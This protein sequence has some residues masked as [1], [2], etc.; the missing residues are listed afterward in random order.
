[1]I[2]YVF[3]RKHNVI[4]VSIWSAGA[5]ILTTRYSVRLFLGDCARMFLACVHQMRR[6]ARLSVRAK[7]KGSPADQW[8]QR[9]PLLDGMV[10]S[11]LCPGPETRKY[12]PRTAAVGMLAT[13]I[14][15][16]KTETFKNTQLWVPGCARRRPSGYD[17]H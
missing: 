10:L 8:E 5:F 2:N 11:S 15:A 14:T 1:M 13:R 3:C 12:R 16:R 9:K 6:W 4:A 7:T 17:T